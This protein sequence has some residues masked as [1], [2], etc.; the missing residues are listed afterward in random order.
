MNKTDLIWE[1]ENREEHKRRL[2]DAKYICDDYIGAKLRVKRYPK[3]RPT[4][5][6]QMKI[7]LDNYAE[8]GFVDYDEDLVKQLD[9]DDALF[10]MEYVEDMF[11]VWIVE[12]VIADAR[13]EIT[14]QIAEDTIFHGKKCSDLEKKYGLKT[15]AIQAR[16]RSIIET[17][18]DIIP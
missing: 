15:R 13:S 14:K 1:H 9:P 7:N 18:A 12:H 6:K 11:N 8:T 17:I 2:K 5:F 4:F 16:K 3:R 10:L